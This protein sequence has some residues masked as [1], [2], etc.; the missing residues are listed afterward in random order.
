MPS[1]G[2]QGHEWEAYVALARS[3][4]T[5][6]GMAYRTRVP[7]SRSRDSS[8][9]SYDAPGRTRESFT[10]RSTTGGRMDNRHAVR[11][12]RIARLE[13]SIKLTAG[14][15]LDI[16]R[17]T[18]SFERGGWKSARKGNSLAAYSTHARFCVGGGPVTA[19]STATSVQYLRSRR[20]TLR[21]Y[22]LVDRSFAHIA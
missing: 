17:V 4:V 9:A 12:M 6:H 19:L 14:E 21:A 15:L 18:S 11:E 22:Q 16:E 10:G 8:R 13:S 20:N 1:E 3:S 7:R 2:I 5:E